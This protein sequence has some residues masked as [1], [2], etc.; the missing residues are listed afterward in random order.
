VQERQG[1]SQ[2]GRQEGAQN[3]PADIL[4]GEVLEVFSL[5]AP[6]DLNPR[7]L[8]RYFDERAGLLVGREQGVYTFV[9]RSFQEYLAACRL[10]NSERDFAG[11]LCQLVSADLDWWREVFLLGVGKQGMGGLSG[12]VDIVNRL[13]PADAGDDQPVDDDQWRLAVLGAE[14]ARDLR[15]QEN[16]AGNAYFRVVHD[17]LRGWL[18]RLLAGDHLP[19]RQRLHAGDLLGILGDPRLGVN[20]VVSA[21]G[22]VQAAGEGLPDIDWVH[23][24]AGEFRMGSEEDDPQALENE[25]P[26]HRLELP[27]FWVSRYPLTNAQYAPFVEQGY[28]EE[29]YWTPEGWAWH[30]GEELDL[31]VLKLL[32]D[33]E[34]EMEI[35]DWILA[36]SK[37][38][39]PNWWG[40]PQ[41]GA[42][43]RPV[44]GVSWFE[45]AAYCRWLDESV[46]RAGLL[47]V[48]APPAY[49]VRL[50]SE[51]EWEK[52][53][54]GTDGRRWSWGNDW[55]EERANTRE[56][57]LGET[58]PVGLFPSADLPY[59]LFD[60]IGNT[61]E[62]TLSKW[63]IDGYNLSYAY[64][65]RADDGR[66][67]PDGKDWRVARGGS[68]YIRERYARC[69]YR[70]RFL[71]TYYDDLLGFRVVLSLAI[72]GF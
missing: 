46:R 60:M 25:K 32:N 50:P 40:D 67:K 20:L 65:Y 47:P 22:K 12:A 10:A 24:P 30:C 36:R 11:K 72:P 39:T 15:L 5:Q 28:A 33:A 71:P 53:S 48:E 26:Q 38:E 61:W 45:A 31:S 13:L 29:R 2:V 57:G 69:A 49:R 6:A 44:V 35:R 21:A 16:A 3:V 58:S 18:V 4:L 66:H 19:V 14:A 68:C 62:W 59:G 7:E 8:V 17:R 70:P 1:S 42:P 55:Q 56:A 64:P 41:W 52:A 63:G 27:G 9:H 23:V 34:L 37:C 43:N 54:R 51:A